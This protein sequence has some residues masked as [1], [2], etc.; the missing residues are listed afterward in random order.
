MLAFTFKE[1]GAE[2]WQTNQ[3]ASLCA[4]M[5]LFGSRVTSFFRTLTGRV[6]I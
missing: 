5:G 4:R 6:G 3:Y 1:L 2:H